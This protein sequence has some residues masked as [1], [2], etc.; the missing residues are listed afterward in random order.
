MDM[1]VSKAKVRANIQGTNKYCSLCSG[2]LFHTFPGDMV[3]ED[4]DDANIN[5]LLNGHCVPDIVLDHLQ[6]HLI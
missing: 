1:L 6:C 3:H 2:S 5:Y 4:D